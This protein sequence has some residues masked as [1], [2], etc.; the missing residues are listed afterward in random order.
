M[1]ASEFI[2][3]Y[4]ELEEYRVLDR[5]DPTWMIKRG[6]S[7]AKKSLPIIQTPLTNYNV[8]YALDGNIHDY[9]LYSKLDDKCIGAFSIEET[10]SLPKITKRLLAPGIRAVTPHMGLAPE[11]QRKGISTQSYSTFLQ[12]GPW[13][14]ITKEHTLGASKLWDSLV[15]GDVVSLYATRKGEIIATPDNESY[16]LLGPRDRFRIT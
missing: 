12:G 15:R 13:V 4:E 7:R 5:Y 9:Y 1:K 2:N 10:D 3:E 11:A 8:R 6:D 14:F 16:R